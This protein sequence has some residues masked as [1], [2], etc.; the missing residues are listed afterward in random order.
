LTLAEPFRTRETVATETPLRLA[1][2][3][4]LAIASS[5]GMVP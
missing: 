2:S 3:R 1:T 5:S 4:M